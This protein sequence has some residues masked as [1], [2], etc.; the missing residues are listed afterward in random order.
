M[1]GPPAVELVALEKPSQE[2]R[3]RILAAETATRAGALLVRTL[4]E[5]GCVATSRLP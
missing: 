5:D 3:C 4:L 1:R 2:R